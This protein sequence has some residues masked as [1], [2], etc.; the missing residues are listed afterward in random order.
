MV[1][2]MLCFSWNI[3]DAICHSVLAHRVQQS[4]L[5]TYT[6]TKQFGMSL[7]VSQLLCF[8]IQCLCYKEKCH[9]CLLKEST[10]VLTGFLEVW[11]FSAYLVV[12]EEYKRHSCL[13]L[14]GRCWNVSLHLY[15]NVKRRHLYCYEMKWMSIKGMVLKV[16]EY[17]QVSFTYGATVFA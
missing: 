15:T 11:C 3:Q 6:T 1:S 13:G 10:R 4:T 14:W 17:K 9:S 5:H 16:W 7:S 8:N 12:S 2:V